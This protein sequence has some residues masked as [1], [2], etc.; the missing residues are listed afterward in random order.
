MYRRL[1][2]QV[3]VPH[4]SDLGNLRT[5]EHWLSHAAKAES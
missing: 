2:A 1:R 4:D 5:F 3:S